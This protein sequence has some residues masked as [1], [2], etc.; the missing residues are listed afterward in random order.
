MVESVSISSTAG[1]SAPLS[2]ARLVGGVASSGASA[3]SGCS[4]MGVVTAGPSVSVGVVSLV[5][6]GMVV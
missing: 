6:V 3:L 1:V 2:V 5:S 4:P